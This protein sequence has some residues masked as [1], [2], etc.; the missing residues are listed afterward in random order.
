MFRTIYRW[1]IGRPLGSNQVESERIPKWKALPIFSSD[2][3]SSVGYGPEQIAIV[4]ASIP[5]LGLYAYFGRVVIAI[6]LLLGIVALSYS[7]IIKANPGGGGSYVIA[8]KYLGEYPALVT[9]AAL[10]SDY[11]LTVAVS[12]SSGTAAITSAFPFLVP[13]HVELDLLVLFTMMVINLRG[14]REASTTFVWPT[15]IFIGCMWATICG[16]LYQIFVLGVPAHALTAQQ[17]APLTALTAVLLLRAFANGC[18]SM[19]GVEAIA[20]GVPMFKV[21]QERN[22]MITT[23]IMATILASMLAGIG[24]LFIHFHMLPMEGRTLMSVLVEQVFGQSLMFFFVQIMTMVILYLAANTAFNG[25]PPLLY[26]MSKDSYV[27]RYLGERGERLSFSNGIILL[28]LG[29]ALLMI[30]FNGDV[31]HLISLY[32]LG[33]FLSFTIA[34]TAICKHWHL[35]KCKYWQLYAGINGLGAVVTG[36]VVIIV[37]MTKFIYGAWIV[38]LLIPTLVYCFKKIHAH[39]EDVREQLVLTPEDYKQNYRT[40]GEGTNYIIVPLASPT[41]AVARAISYAKVIGV[42]NGKIYAVHV[43]TDEAKGEKVKRLWAG[44]EPDIELVVVPSPYRQMSTPLI[45]FIE[46][47]RQ[48]NKPGD[49]ITVVIPEFETRKLWHRFMHNQSGWLLR[50]KMLNYMD[51]VVAT[52]PLQFKR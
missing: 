38:V 47:L 15:Y 48:K 46:R 3:L 34:Q 17:P 11:L 36:V 7:Q 37:L 24:F 27:P 1:L 2:A 39:Y 28:T 29:A 9:G 45:D 13:Y 19:T 5:A 43:A 8:K 42:T 14:V 23:G 16:G 18:S 31:D 32:A 35:L 26:F 4:L 51:V 25:M 41:Q 44:L 10:F 33:V 12:I 52:V 49:M 22:A 40:N 30:V 50:L 21:P 20:D 6:I